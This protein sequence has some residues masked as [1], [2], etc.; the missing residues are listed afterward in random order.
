M[1]MYDFINMSDEE[2]GK[3]VKSA[4]IK[5]N[6]DQNNMQPNEKSNCCN[7]DVSFKWVGG[8]CEEIYCNVCGKRCEVIMK[9][10]EPN[11]NDLSEK[12][13]EDRFWELVSGSTDNWGAPDS[14]GCSDL[15]L[16]VKSLLATQKKEA[17]KAGLKKAKECVPEKA[18]EAD[19]WNM[20]R[21]QSC[22][23]G[24]DCADGFNQART[25]TLENIDKEIKM[26]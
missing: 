26:L 11:E 15:L 8:D 4:V 16:F 6:E 14:D 3:I 17:Y 25:Q 23:P 2:K 12:G 20:L 18:T 1:S 5:S 21:E 9:V 22:C 7:E 10:S 13:W 19:G 24:D